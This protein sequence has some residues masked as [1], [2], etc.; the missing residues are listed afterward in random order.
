[1]ETDRRRVRVA[2][3]IAERGLTSRR[4]AEKWIEEGRVSVNGAVID[5]PAVVVDP[6]RD[7]VAVDGKRLPAPPDRVYY[8]MYKPRG[9]IVTREDPE[10]RKTI[11][12]LLDIED[13]TV[14]AVGRLDFDTEGA[15]I[16]TNDGELAH[17]LTHPSRQ[18][19]KR[20]LVKVYRTPNESDLQAIRD[21]VFLED[22]KTKPALV[23]VMDATDKANAWVEV[24]VTEGRNRLVRRV[25]A[26]LGHPVSKLRR[27][28]FATISIRGMD[29]GQV[30]RLTHAEVQRLRD[31]AEG[32]KPAR[33]GKLKRGK[34]FALPKPKPARKL[35]SSR[36]GK[37][38]SRFG[39]DKAGAGPGKAGA[40]K[41]KGIRKPTGPKPPSRP[42]ATGGEQRPQGGEQRP[43]GGDKRPQGGG[44]SGPGP[45]GS[46][47]GGSRGG[48]SRGGG[49]R[50]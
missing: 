17:A 40:A 21:G 33:A 29:R 10:G 30:R 6:D 46:R 37:G 20:Y 22:G 13:T 50:R 48:G 7:T 27:E 38:G 43:R 15:L 42:S 36:P 2:K 19:P 32:K 49:S 4:D 44:R 31:L 45:G 1:M 12:D 5:T 9:C 16:L 35:G 25:F 34:G 3:L 39:L 8:L 23:R 18:V 28:S 47:G 14:Q 41:G 11:W 26:Q 24:T